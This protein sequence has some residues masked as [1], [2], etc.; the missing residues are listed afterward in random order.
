MSAS[1]RFMFFCVA[2]FTMAFLA[3]GSMLMA[4][5]HHDLLV[6]LSFVLGIALAGL[7]FAMR[8][9]FV[10]PPTAD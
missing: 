8:R 9:R 4:V 3:A 10:K 6:T 5:G 2:L 1:I 7:G